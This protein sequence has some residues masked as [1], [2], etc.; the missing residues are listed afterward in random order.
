M[1]IGASQATV[2]AKGAA[3]DY[4]R[5]ILPWDE[6]KRQVTDPDTGV[7]SEVSLDGSFLACAIAGMMTKYP[8]QEPLT[9][10]TMVGFSATT[11]TDALLETE[12]NELAAKGV[13][14]LENRGGIISIRHGMTTDVATAE[15]NEISVM[16]IRDN[17]IK[18]VRDALDRLYI[19]TVTTEET[20]SDIKTDTEAVLS[21]LIEDGSITDFEDIVVTQNAVD[22]TRF[23]V[24]FKITPAYPIN[25]I[26]ITFTI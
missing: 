25:T 3:L 22:A 14:L 7:T 13:T 8:V 21:L 10:K 18:I 15:D 24:S 2:K 4:N 5:M 6:I 16:L 17:T 20:E 23:D 9:R 12:K 26:F 19:A 11:K 1:P